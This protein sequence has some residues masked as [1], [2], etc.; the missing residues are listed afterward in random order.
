VTIRVTLAL[1]EWAIKVDPM[2]ER[3]FELLIVRALKTAFRSLDYID[4]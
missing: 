1:N 2:D 3:G 4:F